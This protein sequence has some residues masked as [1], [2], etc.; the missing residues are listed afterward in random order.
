MNDP[1]KQKVFRVFMFVRLRVGWFG[2]IGDPSFGKAYIFD[3]ESLNLMHIYYFIATYYI[4][5][6]GLDGEARKSKKNNAESC[7]LG[8]PVFI[9][10]LM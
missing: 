4:L 3:R 9:R 2:R 10:E 6:A 8:Q 7:G 1:H 5:K